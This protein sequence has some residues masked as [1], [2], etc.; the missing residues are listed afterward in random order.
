M[1]NPCWII[2]QEP[3][4]SDDVDDSID[5]RV[6]QRQ[7]S[8]P[9]IFVK[10]TNYPYAPTC[11]LYTHLTNRQNPKSCPDKNDQYY[12]Y[13]QNYG[14]GGELNKVLKTFLYNLY[15]SSSRVYAQTRHEGYK[16]LWSNSNT[17]KNACHPNIYKENPMSCSFISFSGCSVDE[18][19]VPNKD[20]AEFEINA[21]DD[22]KHLTLLH[23]GIDVKVL[24]KFRDGP[25]PMLRYFDNSMTYSAHLWVTLRVYAFILRPN[26]KTRSLIRKS[27]RRIKTLTINGLSKHNHVNH[28]VR[29]GVKD[30]HKCIGIH[31]RNH[32]VLSDFRNE[33]KLD[34]SLNAHVHAAKN[35]SSKLAINEFFLAT[36]N[37]TLYKIAP[38]E[39][40]QWRWQAQGRMIKHE[41]D[42]YTTHLSEDEP[43]TELANLLADSLQIGKCDG[44]V[45]ASDSSLTLIYQIYN[46]N[47]RTCSP[48][49]DILTLEG[50]GIL[51]YI[52]RNS[53]AA[54]IATFHYPWKEQ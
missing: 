36:D 25:G 52:G 46:C 29:L 22:G 34:R 43:Q 15:S 54:T 14:F 30:L 40:P 24:K 8:K 47:L 5:R 48:F 51:P 37:G 26:Y 7:K 50:Q 3:D 2:L 27:N 42:K 31:V 12:H 1:N 11:R 4:L 17:T 9:F 23:L 16:W 20:W 10:M 39:F 28:H 45:G 38:I 13:L 49:F 33:I 32:D 41:F 6:N 19:T 53:S 44:I 35:L 21:F 18:R